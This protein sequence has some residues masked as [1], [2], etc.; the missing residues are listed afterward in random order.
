MDEMRAELCRL[1]VLAEQVKQSPVEHVVAQSASPSGRIEA[2]LLNDCMVALGGDVP[3]DVDSD[4]H[5]VV[6]GVDNV[7]CNVVS[8]GEEVARRAS[9]D[10]SD[11]DSVLS[12]GDTHG[13]ATDGCSVDCNLALPRGGTE[14][15]Q[16][17]DHSR[18]RQ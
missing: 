3:P 6:L 11:C 2:Y 18:A 15:D 12:Q 10:A 9:G 5:I 7:Y 8:S 4:P 14:T 16:I 1:K 13:N 17:V